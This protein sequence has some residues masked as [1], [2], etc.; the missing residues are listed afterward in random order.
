[1]SN[2]DRLPFRRDYHPA[3][4]K[5]MRHRSRRRGGSHD[6]IEKR[7]H[8][9]HLFAT[10]LFANNIQIKHPDHIKAKHVRAYVAYLRDERGLSAGTIKNVA[11]CLRVANRNL[12]KSNKALGIP[13][14]SREGKHWPCPKWLYER[15]IAELSHPG[16][17]V[18]V[19]LQWTLGL[20]LLEAI[21][22]GQSLREWQRDLQR[23]VAT[24][25]VLHG[26]KGG[27]LRATFAPDPAAALA[28]V[29]EGLALL[30]KQ[31]TPYLVPA[32]NRK[33]AVAQFRKC[34]RPLGLKGPLAPHSLRYAYTHR[35]ICHLAACGFSE[36]EALAFAA[37]SLGHGDGRGR[38]IRQVYGRHLPPYES[39]RQQARQ[40][41]M[42]PYGMRAAQDWSGTY[43]FW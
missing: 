27:R 15:L 40:R 29:E 4:D 24:V 35:L 42:R 2:N 31:G 12:P 7:D 34:T 5:E 33:A 16:V 19:K 11:A 23:P 32:K 21:S 3:L 37:L 6:T 38:W 41:Q 28:A 20:R 10:W 25:R 18:A 43:V 26:T 8:V 9:L 1:M 17:V 22:A 36:N 13:R 39:L 14:R 30:K